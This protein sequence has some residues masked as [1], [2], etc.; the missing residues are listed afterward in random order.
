ML[1]YIYHTWILWAIVNGDYKPTSTTG[2]GAPPC[3]GRVVPSN[4]SIF[5][6][7][8]ASRV[9]M[10][11]K[12]SKKMGICVASKHGDAQNGWF[13]SWKILLNWMFEGWFISWKIPLN[14]MI[15]RGSHTFRYQRPFK[16]GLHPPHEAFSIARFDSLRV[17][18]QVEQCE[19]HGSSYCLGMMT[20][21]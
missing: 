6:D 10:A 1:A 3:R 21:F 2:G 13:I 7:S 18:K 15:T 19:H 4:S 9:T 5:R 12:A 16:G 8:S 14:W 17:N 20:Y 11:G